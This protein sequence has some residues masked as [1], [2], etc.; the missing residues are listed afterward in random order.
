[1]HSPL[2]PYPSPL[3]ILMIMEFEVLKT[4]GPARLG[5]CRTPHGVFNT[6][7]FM[8][9]G[10]QA[11]VKAMTPEEL[12]ESG[13]EIILANTYHL[14]LRPG[15]ELIGRLGGLHQFMHWHPPLLTDS[16][17]FQVYS[18]NGLVRVGEEGVRFQSHLD[19]SA[20]LLTPEKAVAIQ[21]AL[22]ADII[23]CFDECTSYPASREQAARSLELTRNWSRRCREAHRRT[24]QAL[25]G[26]VQGGMYPDLRR[27]SLDG[28][29]EI[30][31]DG[32]ALGGLSVG[33]E[34]E[35]MYEVLAEI[36]PLL[37]AGRL[38][39]VMGVGTPLDILEA[40]GRGVD[41]FDCVLPTRNARNGMLFTRFGKMVIKNARYT[42]DPSPIDEGCTCYA[43]RHYSRAYL[44]HLYLSGEILSSRL[45][46][47]HNL[48]FYFGLMEDIRRAIAAD[49]LE[50][51]TREFRARWASAEPEGTE[52]GRPV[53]RLLQTD[54]ADRRREKSMVIHRD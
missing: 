2:T 54:S 18:L 42:E 14:Y 43:C 27:E 45:N 8:A 31:F 29:R 22:G 39:Y 40:V 4:D 7:A 12:R 37:P 6:P 44:R 41:M 28:L 21:E 15:H 17:G 9:V 26:I 47:I 3:T 5:R 25:F 34:K 24:D 53:P 16:G 1:M 20:H 50:E 46:T 32:Y 30:G 13:A 11:T 49:R 36:A 23:M 48:H 52:C 51:F 35:T 10:T 33:E 19:G 38:R